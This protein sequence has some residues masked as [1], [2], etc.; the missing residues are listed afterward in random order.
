MYRELLW[1]FTQLPDDYIVLDTET[2]GLLDENGSPDIVTLG[3]TVVRHRALAESVEFKTRPQKRISEEAQSIH[4]IS[5]EQAAEFESFESQW[6]QIAEYLQDQLIVIHNV[7]FD[8]SILLDHVSRYALSMP[9]IQGVFCS[10]KAAI[11][12]AQAMNLLCS[13]RGPSLDILTKALG[14]ENLRTKIGGTHGAAI[15]SQQIETKKVY[16]N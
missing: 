14:V 9:P 3:L 15:D 2:T 4:G 13:Q 1:I 6:C 8:W 12:W 16:R 5:N 11:P 7:S 10:Q